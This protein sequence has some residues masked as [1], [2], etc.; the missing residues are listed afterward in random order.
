VARHHRIRR[1]WAVRD[2]PLRPLRVTLS[3][4]KGAC[5]KACPLRC[6]QGDSRRAPTWANPRCPPPPPP[7]AR[8]RCPLPHPS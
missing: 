3:A 7:A 4:A 8:T 5:L 6:A 2:A 1:R